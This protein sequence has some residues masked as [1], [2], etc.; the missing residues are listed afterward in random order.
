MG[1]LPCPCGAGWDADHIAIISRRTVTRHRYVLWLVASGT[2]PL[3]SS[4]TAPSR[5]RAALSLA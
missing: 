3:P 5:G 4:T 1:V 2:M